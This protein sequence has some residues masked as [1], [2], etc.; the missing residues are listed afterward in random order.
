M[1]RTIRLNE[2]QFMTLIKNIISESESPNLNYND[3]LNLPAGKF[4]IKDI[5][6]GAVNAIAFEGYVPKINRNGKNIGERKIIEVRFHKKPINNKYTIELIALDYS[7]EVY[8]AFQAIDAFDG[9]V[10]DYFNKKKIN[11]ESDPNKSRR[12]PSDEYFLEYFVDI[13]ELEE[14]KKLIYDFFN[15]QEY[16]KEIK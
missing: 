6:T 8:F 9:D 13:N 14:F 7:D 5:N 12:T 4:R 1:K 3:F 10:I 15:N 16:N 2:S 11:F